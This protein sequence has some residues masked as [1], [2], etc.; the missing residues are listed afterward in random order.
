MMAFLPQILFFLP[1]VPARAHAARGYSDLCAADLV[2][3]GKV[4]GHDQLPYRPPQT[5]DPVDLEPNSSIDIRLAIQRTLVGP[6]SAVISFSWPQISELE[7][8]RLGERWLLFLSTS[9]PFVPYYFLGERFVD[10]GA[11]LGEES[12]LAESWALLCYVYF[13][14]LTFR[15]HPMRSFLRDIHASSFSRPNVR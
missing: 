2:V 15:D 13:E 14:G 1:Q 8:L 3:V 4:V 12:D 7:D 10:P 5:D 6:R 11:T 9:N